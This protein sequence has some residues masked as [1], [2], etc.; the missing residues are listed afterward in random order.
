MSSGADPVP[1]RSVDVVIP[2]Y[3]C[4]ATIVETLQSVFNQTHQPRC[5]Y[6]VDDGSTDGTVALVKELNSP[7]V[8]VLEP[9]RGGVSH[10]RNA[11]IKAGSSRYVAFLDSDDLWTP[12]K[13]ERQIKALEQNPDCDVVHCVFQ[14]IDVSSEVIPESITIPERSGSIFEDIL[15]HEVTVGGSASGVLVTRKAIDSIGGFDE[16]LSFSEDVD[17]WVRLAFKYR[18]ALVDK[19]VVQIRV[20][21][22]SATRTSDPD[23]KFLIPLHHFIYLDKWTDHNALSYRNLFRQ[24]RRMAMAVNANLSKPR[25]VVS[26]YSRIKSEA[27]SFHKQFCKNYIFFFGC[28]FYVVSWLLIQRVVRRL[29]PAR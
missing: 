10:A 15:I 13:L 16:R 8:Q 5:I 23:R 22:A 28:L 14:R 21:P 2:A 9:G 27:P 26:F 19:P 29:S 7:L 12:D 1:D 17:F 25:K 6:V 18:F 4:T 3:N 11:G 24:Y 20:N